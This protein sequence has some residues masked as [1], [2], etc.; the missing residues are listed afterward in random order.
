MFFKSSRA[1]PEKICRIFQSC[2]QLALDFAPLGGG[3]GVAGLL[4]EQGVAGGFA[5]RTVS[6]HENQS[7]GKL[8]IGCVDHDG[9]PF[10]FFVKLIA[11]ELSP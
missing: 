10:S 4:A 9:L 5:G 2:G 6:M 11:L 7:F 3:F 8:G 1:T